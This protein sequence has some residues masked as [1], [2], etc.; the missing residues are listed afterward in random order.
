V[1]LEA[2]ALSL[3]TT[4]APAAVKALA[5]ALDQGK[6]EEEALA[7]ARAHLPAR[8]DTTVEDAARHQ[9]ILA[10]TA[11]SRT[12]VSVADVSVGRLLAASPMLSTEERASA[13]RLS[14]HAA[15]TLGET[16]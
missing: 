13:Q 14:D 6:S 2:L 12:R 16:P 11:A 9:R 8:I 7:A 1:S 15:I 10:E 5:D 4:L 3:L